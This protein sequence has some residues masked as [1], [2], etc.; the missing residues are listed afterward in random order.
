MA[1]GEV[2]A[3]AFTSKLQI[4][5]LMT[6]HPA[7]PGAA[8]VI[9]QADRGGG[10]HRREAIRA[11]CFKVSSGP[12][13]SWFMKPAG[14]RARRGAGNLKRVRMRLGLLRTPG[15]VQAPLQ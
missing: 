2:D 7:P 10:A 9:A 12:K 14:D 11:H 4:D 1:A 8:R 6:Q 13:H 15:T 3:I 5:R